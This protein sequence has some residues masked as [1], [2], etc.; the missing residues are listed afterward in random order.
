MV[1]LLFLVKLFFGKIIKGKSGEFRFVTIFL[2]FN[3]IIGSRRAQC[4]I[5]TKE[6]IITMV[7]DFKLQ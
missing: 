7:P 1:Q 5:K 4:R 2:A 6:I 3:E